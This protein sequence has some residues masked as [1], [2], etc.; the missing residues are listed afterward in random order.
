MQIKQIVSLQWKFVVTYFLFSQI[1]FNYFKNYLVYCVSIS[2]SLIQKMKFES[3]QDEDKSVT[4][5]IV[6]KWLVLVSFGLNSQESYQSIQDLELIF[7]HCII[8]NL[9]ICGYL[10]QYY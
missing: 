5:T 6:Y 2:L 8:T 7:I 9:V 10:L 4:K 3:K 1:I